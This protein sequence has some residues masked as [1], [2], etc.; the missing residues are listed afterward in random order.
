MKKASIDN[1]RSSK[2]GKLSNLFILGVG[3]LYIPLVHSE[4]LANSSIDLK[5]EV[6]NIKQKQQFEIRKRMVIKKIQTIWSRK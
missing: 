3:F 4:Q 6:Q 2:F 5:K 1:I